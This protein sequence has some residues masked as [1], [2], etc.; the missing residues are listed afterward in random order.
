MNLDLLK[1]ADAA[2]L[3]S[4][5]E[6]LLWHYS[7]ADGFWFIYTNEKFDRATAEGI[8]E[9]VWDKAGAMAAKE[10]VKRFASTRKACVVL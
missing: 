4:Y 3:R 9:R 1:N 8:N 2:E 5:I 7:V 10:I 6:F